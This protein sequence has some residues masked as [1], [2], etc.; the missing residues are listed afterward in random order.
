MAR[1][2]RPQ[3]GDAR[4][5]FTNRDS[6]HAAV[7]MLSAT[8]KRSYEATSPD[9]DGV[10][11]YRPCRRLPGRFDRGA[12]DALPV[13][14]DNEIL[15]TLFSLLT[16]RMTVLPA[17]QFTQEQARALTGVTPETLRHWRKN[18]P[19]LSKKSGKAARFTFSELVGLAITRDLIETFAVGISSISTGIDFLFQA[20]AQ[21]KPSELQFCVAIIAKRAAALRRGDDQT[22]MN[23]TE[24][25]LL[26]ACGPVIER[27]RGHVLPETGQDA[28]PTLPFPPQAV[29]G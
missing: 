7:F 10:N 6:E 29:R 2:L 14:R 16:T 27:I 5:H 18:V 23:L 3:F 22:A 19:Y 9:S 11:V 8:V 28:Q 13:A 24:P 1:E 17:I 4:R 20:L 12:K 26:L 21:S 25:A 15:A